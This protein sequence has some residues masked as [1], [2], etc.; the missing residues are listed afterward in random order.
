MYLIGPILGA[1]IQGVLIF[2]MLIGLDFG[3]AYIQGGVLTGFY[4]IH[5]IKLRVHGIKTY[6]INGKEVL[7]GDWEEL[8]KETYVCNV[9]LQNNFKVCFCKQI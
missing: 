3:G 2:G 9:C 1:H 7:M 8:N 5:Y 6:G 4:R